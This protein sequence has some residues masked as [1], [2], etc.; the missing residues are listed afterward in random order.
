MR[1]RL[2]LARSEA[3]VRL[4]MLQRARSFVTRLDEAREEKRFSRIPLARP[5]GKSDDER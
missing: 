5:E 1:I 3:S 4:A 2:A